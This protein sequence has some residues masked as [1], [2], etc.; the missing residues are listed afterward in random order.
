MKIIGR[1]RPRIFPLN[2]E[3]QKIHPNYDFHV[4]S[5]IFNFELDLKIEKIIFRVKS[6]IF[7]I[8]REIPGFSFTII[9]GILHLK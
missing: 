6:R 4:F 8:R 5:A 9:F 2:F 1:V 7:E 3:Y